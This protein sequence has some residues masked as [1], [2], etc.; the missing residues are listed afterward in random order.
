M[1]ENFAGGGDGGKFGRSKGPRLRRFNPVEVGVDLLINLM[2]SFSEDMEKK[3]GWDVSGLSAFGKSARA[4]VLEVLSENKPLLP[5]F[6][7][8]MKAAIF[9]ALP[10]LSTESRTAINSLLDLYTDGI[11][12]AMAEKDDDKS[13]ALV[14]TASA[15]FKLSMTR[16]L[17]DAAK[18]RK[19][20]PVFSELLRRLT[21]DEANELVE[22]EAWMAQHSDESRKHWLG[23]RGNISSDAELRRILNRRVQGDLGATTTSRINYVVTA[24]EKPKTLAEEAA[25]TVRLLATGEDTPQ[26]RAIRERIQG[27]E[28][29]LVRSCRETEAMNAARERL[30]A[31]NRPSHPNTQPGLLQRIRSWFAS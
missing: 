13:E 24:Y 8:G 2:E 21:D 28:A 19:A 15:N 17:D 18:Q 27:M 20:K 16:L 25:E 23:L 1:A 7:T 29:E 31:R 11:R 5:F 26:T 9:A 3:A 4:A 22:W 12:K 30:Y 14:S 6:E 10:T